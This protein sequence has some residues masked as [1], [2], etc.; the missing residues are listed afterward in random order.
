MSTC[1][2]VQHVAPER[3]FSIADALDAEGVD[4][5]LCRVFEGDVVPADVTG[6]D[7]LVVMGGPMAADSD[8]DFCSRKAELGL[9]A[10]AIAAQTPTLG[11]CLGAQLVAKAAGASVRRGERGLE[12]GWSA[13]TL[14]EEC[15]QDPLFAGLPETLVVLQ[16]HGD[17]FDL[18]PGAVHLIRNSTYPNQGFRLGDVVW[19]LQFH[20]EVDADAVCGFL[21]AFGSDAAG[22]PGCSDAIRTETSSAVAALTP[23]R[24][25][26]LGRFARMVAARGKRR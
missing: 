9:I 12:I 4:V 19:G 16:W 2:V 11:V 22:I 5:D 8:Q 6:L 13:V 20:L 18:P 7:G 17:T 3:A 14:T 10:A 15:D 24:D 26:V 1:L 25:L 23:S 21:E